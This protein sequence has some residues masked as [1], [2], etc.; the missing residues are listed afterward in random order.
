MHCVKINN[1]RTQLSG[2]QHRVPQGSV[3]GPLLFLFGIN[4]IRFNYN[5]DITLCA[6]DTAIFSCNKNIQM[7]EIETALFSLKPKFGLLQMI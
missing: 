2:I 7:L 4:D 5:S 1:K 3:L 6:Y